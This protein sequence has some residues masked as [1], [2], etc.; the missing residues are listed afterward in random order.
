M[1][2]SYDCAVIGGGPAGCRAAERLSARGRR[3][4]LIEERAQTLGGTCLN[5]GCVPVKALLQAAELR[6]KISRSSDFGIVAHADPLEPGKIQAYVRQKVARLRQG[7]LWGLE[8]GKVEIVYGRAAFLAPGRARVS[9]E[10]GGEREIR[11]ENFVLAPGSVPAVLPGLEPDG[12]AVFDS[13]GILEN[14]PGTE[15]VLIVGGGYIG[16]EFASFFRA[17]GAGVVLVESAPRLL[18][19]EDEELS[20]V[21]EREFKKRGVEVLAGHR[22]AGLKRLGGGAEAK[23]L[24]AGTG[25]PRR[26]AAEKVLVCVGRKPRT[27]GLNL[28][29]L[30]IGLRDGFIP[31][32]V[33]MRTAASGVYAAGDAIGA[34]MLA[35]AAGREAD[36]AAAALAGESLPPL[37]YGLVPRAVFSFPQAASLGL[38]ERE[39]RAV[40][41]ETETEKKFFKANAR[42]VIAGEEGG[43]AKLVFARSSGKLL[44]AGIVGPEACELI[45]LLAWPLARGLTREEMAGAVY[46]HP[47]FSEILA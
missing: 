21:L 47:T 10:G 17:L 13:D 12:E 40:G 31:V 4:C 14:W 7:L 44:G 45:H 6:E 25:A 43:L 3:V 5:R 9:L 30:G 46:G 28:E 42:A 32:E 11:S 27:A 34:A 29:V 23:I 15:S 22:V 41:I 16:C 36:S 24:S 35:H 33:G 18:P 2:A 39:A 1:R 37:D 26:V 19:R 8:K 20:R 38:T